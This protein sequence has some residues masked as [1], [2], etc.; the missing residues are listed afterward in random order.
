MRA[1]PAHLPRA[2]HVD[3]SR[4][5]SRRAVASAADCAAGSTTSNSSFIRTSSTATTAVCR[6]DRH[7]A[8]RCA[9]IRSVH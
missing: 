4:C 7:N 1:L 2:Q 5:K 6:C 9:R 8:R 3:S